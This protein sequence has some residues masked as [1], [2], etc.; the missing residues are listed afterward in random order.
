MDF[1]HRFTAR[2]PPSA[3]R[4]IRNLGVEVPESEQ[5][6][7]SETSLPYVVFEVSEGHPRWAEIKEY[8]AKWN[9]GDYCTTRF[10]S[11]ELDS[12][13]WLSLGAGR[14][15]YPE[16]NQWDAGY[17]KVTYSLENYC[18]RCGMGLDQKAPFRMKGEPRLSRRSIFQLN[19]ISDE[20]F[21]RPEIWSLAF[22]QHGIA[23][24][25]V[26]DKKG[27][28]LD[29][30]VQIVVEQEVSILVDELDFTE[31]NA[32]GRRKYAHVRRG[33]MPPL[34]EIPRSAIVRTRE[35]FGSGG[36]AGRVILISQALR[37]SMLKVQVR[38]AYFWPVTSGRGAAS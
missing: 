6:E 11:E 25:P 28:K 23:C 9:S 15:W 5:Y 13:E 29:S 22:K 4:K 10:T 31:C 18:P 34:L 7:A 3:I 30:V 1:I 33:M 37:R 35:S 20:L 14:Y 24:R 21:V 32:C 19:W 16:P 38:G 2:I 8:I 12:A 36:S 17:L 26:H 27:R